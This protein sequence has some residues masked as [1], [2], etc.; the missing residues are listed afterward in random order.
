ML[1][2][3]PAHSASTWARI[4]FSGHGVETGLAQGRDGVLALAQDRLQYDRF[5]ASDAHPGSVRVT[6][7]HPEFLACDLILDLL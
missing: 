1:R 6:N 5:A 2:M 3:S 4:V 7:R